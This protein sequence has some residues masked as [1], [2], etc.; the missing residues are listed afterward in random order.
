V[1]PSV[2][3][4]AILKPVT[5]FLEEVLGEV[6][7][8]SNLSDIAEPLIQAVEAVPGAGR[9]AVFIDNSEGLPSFVSGPS[10]HANEIDAL[11]R[12]I[13]GTGTDD[14]SGLVADI[15]GPLDG[16]TPNRVRLFP[17]RVPREQPSAILVTVRDPVDDDDHPLFDNFMDQIVQL[18]GVVVEDRRLRS[19]MTDQQSVLQ[20][21]VNTAPD[22]IIRMGRDGTILDFMG[23]ASRIF[24]WSPEEIVGQSISILMP[25]PDASRHGRYVDTFLQTGERKLP[26]FGRRLTARHKSGSNFPIEVALSQLPG[27]EDVEFI[28]TVRDISRRVAQE[29]EIDALR[30]ALDAAGRQSALGE[31]AATIAHELNQPLTA[32]ANYMDALELRLANPDG[33]TIEVARDFARKTA[34]QARLGA[35]V[36]RRTRRM[37]LHGES[38]AQMDD[39][40]DAVRE[41]VSLISKTPRAAATEIRLDHEGTSEPTAFDRVQIQQVVINLAS[42]ALRAMANTEN[43]C[44]TLISR[45]TE[46]VLELVVRDNGPGILPMDQG[47]VFDRFFRRSDNGMGL[48]LS[49]VRRIAMAHDGEVRLQDAT[50][51]GA[52]FTLTLPRRVV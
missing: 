19:K 17:L 44:L 48:G 52:E 8:S 3:L 41:A 32:I 16:D 34:A 25:D 9:V 6:G 42:N 39:F 38:H 40:H 22:A 15:V 21:L 36:I 28:G 23:G 13:A 27:H 20:A 37:A 14:G 11:S 49:I 26:D 18:A 46:D 4:D 5:A 33:N 10:F 29:G 31:L 43:P 7:S 2:Y 47:K 12:L 51:G 45:Q 24:G 1:D 50:G 30:D 35:E